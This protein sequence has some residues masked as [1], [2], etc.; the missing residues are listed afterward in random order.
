MLKSFFCHSIVETKRA[1]ARQ[2]IKNPEAGA[3]V[4]KLF[5]GGIKDDHDEDQLREYFSNYGNVQNVSIVTDKGTG[6]KRGFGFVEFDDYDPVDKICCEYALVILTSHSFAP[7]WKI[8][9]QVWLPLTVDS[10]VLILAIPGCHFSGRSG[11]QINYIHT[12]SIN[13]HFLFS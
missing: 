4:K 5:I 11:T 6:K 9:V 10:K 2:D 1:V 12:V 8:C 3:T 7:E 13:L